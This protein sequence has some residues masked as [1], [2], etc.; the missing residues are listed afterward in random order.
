MSY[1]QNEHTEQNQQPSVEIQKAQATNMQ[2]N[3]SAPQE[4]GPRPDTYLVWA[5]LATLFCCLPFGVV[6]IVYAAQVDSRWAEHRYDEA[7]RNSRL[8]KNWALA[9]AISGCVGILLYIVF[10]GGAVLLSAL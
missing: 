7:Y 5:I 9:A 3:A 6:S 2:Q 4:P 8:A 10:V 1:E